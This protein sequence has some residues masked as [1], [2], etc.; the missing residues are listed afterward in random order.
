[1]E[2]IERGEIC[3]YNFKCK[4]CK[5]IDC[6]NTLRM[7]EE[8]QKMWFKTKEY[9]FKEVLEKEYPHCVNCSHL[10]ILNMNKFKVRCPYMINKR[11]AIERYD[12][13]K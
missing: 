5:L 2:C 4:E 8:E 3:V 6:R 7:I 12:N 10:E 11:C 13:I 9:H 1:M